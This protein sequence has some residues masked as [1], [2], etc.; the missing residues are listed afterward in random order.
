MMNDWKMHIG[1]TP[2][3]PWMTYVGWAFVAAAEPRAKPSG[4]SSANGPPARSSLETS[5]AGFPLRFG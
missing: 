4:P 1:R 3:M 5:D 2:L